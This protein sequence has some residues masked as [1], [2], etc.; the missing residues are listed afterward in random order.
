MKLDRLIG[1]LSILL[2]RETVTAAEL[3][4]TFEVSRRTIL[5]DTDSLARAGIPIRT[6]QGAGGGISLMENYKIDRTLL[7]GSELQAILAGLR[8]LDSVSGTSQYALLMEKLAPG[9]SR[10]LPG[11]QH[12]L[13]DLAS[14]YRG[15]LSEKIGTIRRAIDEN[16]MLRFHYTAPGGESDRTAE[17]YCILFQWG[18][19]YLWGWCRNRQDFRLFKLNRMTELDTA[20]SFTPR[21]APLPDLSDERVFPANYHVE[22]RVDGR[23][24]WRLLEE[25]GADSFTEEPDGRCLFRTDFT[26]REQV[27][28]WVLSFGGAAEL[29]T[30][31]ELRAE[32]A[33]MGEKIAALHRT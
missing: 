32:L 2:R 20:G 25:Y 7:T 21:P 30:P 33:E 9:A 26:S 3:A 29:L 19:W 12:I 17:P 11:D 31:A 24:K 22:M 10:L 27:L 18:S 13:I 6:R 28:R 23:F 16:R 14:W 15:P 8:S 5:R 4:E 1:I